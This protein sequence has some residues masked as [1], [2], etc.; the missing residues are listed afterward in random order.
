MLKGTVSGI[1][2]DPPRKDVNARFTTLFRICKLIIFNC[3]FSTKV[4]CAFPLQ[5]NIKEFSELKAFKPWKTTISSTWL[6]RFQG[7]FVNRESLLGGSLEI[8]LTVTLMLNL[9]SVKPPSLNLPAFLNYRIE[10]ESWH[11]IHSS[12]I[13]V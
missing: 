1:S 6:I 11:N 5:E 3:G 12:F 8:T 7:T 9:M 10:K 13:Y 2:S 4:A